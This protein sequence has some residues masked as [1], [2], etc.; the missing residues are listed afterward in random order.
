MA[1]SIAQIFAP[2]DFLEQK[3]RTNSLLQ[4]YVDWEQQKKFFSER[5]QEADDVVEMLSQ[6]I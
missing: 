2:S 4:I 3:Q 5:I 6:R 1:R